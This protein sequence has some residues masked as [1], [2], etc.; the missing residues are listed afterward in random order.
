MTT[1]WAGRLRNYSIPSRGK[2]FLSSPKWTDWLSELNPPNQWVTRA[3]SLGLKSLV[4]EAEQ[5]PPSSF[6]VKNESRHTSTVQYVLMPCTGKT[7]PLPHKS[8]VHHYRQLDTE[9]YFSAHQ[10]QVK[11]SDNEYSITF[12]IRGPTMS[13]RAFWLDI[14]RE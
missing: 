2:I 12:I 10:K 4:H 8:H 11:N 14:W 13:L 1:L 7:L 5:P 3:P 6:Q 9:Y